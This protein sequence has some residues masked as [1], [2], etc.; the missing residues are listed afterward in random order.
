MEGTPFL[1][2]AAA[3]ELHYALQFQIESG[4]QYRLGSV[5][6]LNADKNKPLAIWEDLLRQKL[7]LNTD[8]L[9]SASKVRNA[10]EGITRVYAARG[11]IDQVPE[12]V[13]TI[14]EADSRVDLL[15]RI[16]EGK[17]YK[18]A[19]ISTVGLDPSAAQGLNGHNLWAI[20]SPQTS[21]VLF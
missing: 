9:F 15:L 12:P 14:R 21:G 1:I 20:I 3:S 16:A 8:D 19:D 18:I 7:E 13:T 6:I 4:P 11:F 2:R 5:H 17:Q 10:M